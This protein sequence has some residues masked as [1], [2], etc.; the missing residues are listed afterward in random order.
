MHTDINEIPICEASISCDNLLCDSNGKPPSP[1]IVLHVRNSHQDGWIKYGRTEIIERS[2]NP[3][4]LCTFQFRHGDTLNSNTRLRLTAFDVRE[5]IS[6]T[7]VPIGYAE[8]QLGQIQ[9]TTRIRIP[10]ELN[11]VTTGFVTITSWA[12]EDEKKLIK[13]PIRKLEQKTLGHRRT[14]SLPPKLGIKL[15]VPPQLK[16]NQ[17]LVNPTVSRPDSTIFEGCLLIFFF[18]F[19]FC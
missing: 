4:F 19:K 13:S 8:I 1:A 7:A 10:F 16:L 18:F 6:K 3:Q 5:K 15:F 11:C 14:Q 9:E 12:A 17:V 2:S